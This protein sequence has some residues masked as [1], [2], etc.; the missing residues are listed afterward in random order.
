MRVECHALWG[1]GEGLEPPSWGSYREVG[2]FPPGGSPPGK[3][4][5]FLKNLHFDSGRKLWGAVFLDR[6]DPGLRA[7]SSQTLGCP[8]GSQGRLIEDT[9]G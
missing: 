8:A 4:C 2:G 9:R 7:S 3:L 6:T 5:W 1:W